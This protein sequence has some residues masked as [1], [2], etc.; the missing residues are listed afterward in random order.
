MLLRHREPLPVP[1]KLNPLVI[2]GY[3]SCN[4]PRRSRIVRLISVDS[5]LV[6]IQTVSGVSKRAVSLKLSRFTNPNKHGFSF[7][8]LKLPR[9]IMDRQ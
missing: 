7:L 3:Y 4:D 9:W 2:N 6:K 1:K 8:G 5:S